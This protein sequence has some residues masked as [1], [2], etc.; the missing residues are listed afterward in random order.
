MFLALISTPLSPVILAFTLLFVSATPTETLAEAPDI[1][2]DFTSIL[3]LSF[4]LALRLIS[5]AVTAEF[6][7][8]A[9]VTASLLV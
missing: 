1:V 5:F 9:F 7:I 3:I 2:A 8:I 6:S 4:D